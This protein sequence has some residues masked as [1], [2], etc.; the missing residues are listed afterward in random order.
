MLAYIC[1]PG[2]LYYFFLFFEAVTV[3][4]NAIKVKLPRM[5][6]L[7]DARR[8]FENVCQQAA[9]QLSWLGRPPA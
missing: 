6:A 3:I 8:A 2:L 1:V 5:P 7:C 4:E 9:S